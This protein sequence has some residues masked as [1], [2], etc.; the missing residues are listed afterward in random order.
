MLETNF[1]VLLVLCIRNIQSYS[2]LITLKNKNIL[3]NFSIFLDN[4]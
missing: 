2:N 1:H 3:M 4:Y